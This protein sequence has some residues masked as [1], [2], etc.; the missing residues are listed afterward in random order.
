MRFP[1]RALLYGLVV[2][3]VP[4]V[5]SM[6]LFPL[7]RAGSPLFESAMAVIVAAVAAGMA[8]I[9]FRRIHHRYLREGLLLGLAWLAISIAIDLPLMLFPPISMS[10]GQYFADIGLTYLMIPIISTAIGAAL[11]S[12][13]ENVRQRLV[14]LERKVEVPEFVPQL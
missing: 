12:H 11:H 4:F 10:A 9:Y 2:W 8:L 1:W 6:L 5:L 14:R 7:K 13:P 3:V